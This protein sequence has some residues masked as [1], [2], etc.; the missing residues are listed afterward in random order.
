MTRRYHKDGVGNKIE[1]LTRTLIEKGGRELMLDIRKTPD[2]GEPDLYA[3]RAFHAPE[4]LFRKEE[5]AQEDIAEVSRVLRWAWR[6]GPRARMR[7]IM[8]IKLCQPKTKK[9]PVPKSA[10]ERFGC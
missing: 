3:P 8:G 7:H 1:P 2:L 9:P 6:R 5:E 10:I 4:E